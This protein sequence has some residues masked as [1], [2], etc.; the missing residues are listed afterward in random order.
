MS[1]VNFSHSQ[2]PGDTPDLHDHSPISSC[3]DEEK[4]ERRPLR[5]P[6]HLEH[7]VEFDS[8]AKLV[9]GEPNSTDGAIECTQSSKN[10]LAAFKYPLL[11]LKLHGLTWK[12][13]ENT[14]CDWCTAYCILVTMMFFV[15]G[16]LQIVKFDGDITLGPVF[17]FHIAVVLSW[18]QSFIGHASFVFG[19]RRHLRKLLEMWEN[20]R[21]YHGGIPY[22]QLYKIASL[23]TIGFNAYLL[24]LFGTG[25][26]VCTFVKPDLASYMVKPFLNYGGKDTSLVLWC[27]GST[28]TFFLLWVWLEPY[29][30]VATLVHLLKR[31]FVQASKDFSKVV[32]DIDGT[33]QAD[34]RHIDIE[35]HRK[36]HLM[37]CKI[38]NKMDDMIYGFLIFTYAIDIPVLCAM[39]F[40]I[41]HAENYPNLDWASLSFGL[42][43]FCYVSCHL[44]AL[45]LNGAFLT[46]AVSCC[47]HLIHCK[48]NKSRIPRL[49]CLPD[50]NQ[51]L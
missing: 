9:Q 35:D 15:F 4:N 3:S 43:W 24:C 23:L 38:T 50:T 40:V 25:I 46:S 49:Q 18:V 11:S 12:S 41:F 34:H 8:P 16:V 22:K 36:R 21:Q 48:P 14:K 1:N 31:E 26:L 45:T 19:T 32:Q 17:M 2:H 39:I 37:L 30:F 5:H 51:I 42:L 20:Y 27:I 29:I 44:A 28:I 10:V 6:V 47:P 33:S 7:E 13:N